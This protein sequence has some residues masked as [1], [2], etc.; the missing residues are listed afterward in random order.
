MTDS[1]FAYTV[2]PD[3]KRLTDNLFIDY[4]IDVYRSSSNYEMLFWDYI[5][6][7]NDKKA[8]QHYLAKFPKGV[9]AGVA[10]LKTHG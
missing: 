7:S 3:I 1:I 9:F 10:R 5:K 4:A 8:F 6:D 2:S